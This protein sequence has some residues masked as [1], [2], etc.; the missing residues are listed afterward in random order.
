MTKSVCRKFIYFSFLLL[1]G[2]FYFPIAHD[3][4]EHMNKP[5]VFNRLIGQNSESI[6][7]TFGWPDEILTDGSKQFFMY[8]SYSDGTWL[9]IFF[10][11]PFLATESDTSQHC[12]RFVVDLNN[13]VQSYQIKS[14]GVGEEYAHGCLSEFWSR[15][16]IEKLSVST[17]LSQRLRDSYRLLKAKEEAEKAKEEAEYESKNKKLSEQGDASAQL[18]MYQILWYEDTGEA[19]RWLCRS[20][21]QGNSDARYRLGQLY[22]GISSTERE[23]IQPDKIQ[24]YVWYSLSG[25]DYDYF[26]YE[27]NFSDQELELAKSALA[28]WQPGQCERSL[29]LE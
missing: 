19:L 12:L 24:A 23:F 21:D 15:K 8:S 17:D 16:Q 3:P 29:G 4:P 18:N 9:F 7:N 20:A 22:Q 25:K 28:Q 5:E 26:I 10:G 27:S 13:V 14:K 1:C 6:V 2:C 11:I